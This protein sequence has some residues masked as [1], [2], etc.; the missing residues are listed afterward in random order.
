V[1]S[2]CIERLAAGA[3]AVGCALGTD[4]SA[5]AGMQRMLPIVSAAAT[6]HTWRFLKIFNIKNSSYRM[7]GSW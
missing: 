2:A 6:P 5:K 7:A 1:A 4:E 3:F